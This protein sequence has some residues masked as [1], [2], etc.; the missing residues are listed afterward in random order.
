MFEMILY[1]ASVG[2]GLARLINDNNVALGCRGL[3]MADI[4]KNQAVPALREFA[5]H[6]LSRIA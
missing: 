2:G 4:P 1:L 5:P 6:L 3:E